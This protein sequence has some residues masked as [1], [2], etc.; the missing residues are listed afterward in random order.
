VGLKLEVSSQGQV[1]AAADGL[2][3]LFATPEELYQARNSQ[4]VKA[5]LDRVFAAPSP[6][7][8]AG[9]RSDFL[10]VLPDIPP[11]LLSATD[12]AELKVTAHPLL[13]V[14]DAPQRAATN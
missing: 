9:G 6:P 12:S 8:P 5:V 11:A 7:I 2:P 3:G 14:A 10:L 13:N 4:E 1:V